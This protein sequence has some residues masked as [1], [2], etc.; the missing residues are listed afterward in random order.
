MLLPS[1]FLPPLPGED[2]ACEKAQKG[3]K[4]QEEPDDSDT[5][6]PS[7]CP[8]NNRYITPRQKRR[9]STRTGCSSFDAARTEH[10]QPVDFDPLY[11]AY[12][13]FPRPEFWALLANALVV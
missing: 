2:N 8:I 4:S 10:D 3:E 7:M 9:L 6:T 5:Q 1:P 12:R 13:K 11:F